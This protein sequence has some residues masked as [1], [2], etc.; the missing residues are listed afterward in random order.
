MDFL[1]DTHISLAEPTESA[2]TENPVF[3]CGPS[4]LC[5]KNS[6]HGE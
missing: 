4:A 2:E 1:V 3:L 6:R 5:G